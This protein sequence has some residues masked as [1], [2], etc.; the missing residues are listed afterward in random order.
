MNDVEH[1]PVRPNINNSQNKIKRTVLDNI[2]DSKDPEVQQ[3]LNKKPDVFNIETMK[4]KE[5]QE[6]IRPDTSSSW[7]IVIL[8]IIIVILIVV[9]IYYVLKYNA[10]STTVAA[11]AVPPNIVKPI[12]HDGYLHNNY[13][14]KLMHPQADIQMQN[15]PVI[16]TKNVNLEKPKNFVEPTKQELDDIINRLNSNTK[17]NTS[18]GALDTLPTITEISEDESEQNTQN[19]SDDGNTDNYVEEQ[20]EARENKVQIDKKIEELIMSDDN[21]D[22]DIIDD[23]IEDQFKKSILDDS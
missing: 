15:I 8:A 11:T 5:E 23:E 7:L 21:L 19:N 6:V 18:S 4:T 13:T 14:Q 2:K 16:N 10:V 3:V 17:N 22:N 1:I 9:V 12:K 20:A